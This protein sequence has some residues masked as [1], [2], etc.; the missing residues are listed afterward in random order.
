MTCATKMPRSGV[1]DLMEQIRLSLAEIR[2][3]KPNADPSTKQV[4]KTPNSVKKRAQ[5]CTPESRTSPRSQA[6]AGRSRNR[7]L[8]RMRLSSCF[9]RMRA[10]T[11]LLTI[12]NQF[13]VA[14]NAH[15]MEGILKNDRPSSLLALI[16][17][18]SAG[19]LELSTRRIPRTLAAGGFA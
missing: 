3:K 1:P 17:K 2:S 13:G 16:S 12:P 4:R 18:C 10:E 9:G 5:G 11:L 14:Y 19:N 15:I 7:F 6:F 8:S